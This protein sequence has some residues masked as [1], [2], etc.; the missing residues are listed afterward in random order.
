[1]VLSMEKGIADLLQKVLQE[2]DLGTLKGPPCRVAGGLMHT[3][4]A[5]VTERGKYAV[6]VLNPAV[7][8]REKALENTIFSEKIARELSKKIPVVPA[9]CKNGEAVSARNGCYYMVFPWQSGKNVF[10]KEIT[11]LHCER[12]GG[13]LGA[14]HHA[15]VQI[16]GAA[17][18]EAG[19][20]AP[21]WKTVLQK[22]RQEKPSWLRLFTA[23][24]ERIAGWTQRYVAAAEKRSGEQV[25]SHRDLDPKNVLWDG[26]EPFLIDW[27]AAG[28]VNPERELIEVVNY[29]ACNQRGR[30]DREKFRA[31]LAAYQMNRPLLHTDWPA[32]LDS[33]YGG[34][35][36]WLLYNMKRSLGIE[37]SSQ[38][39]RRLGTAQVR[40]TLHALD[41]YERKTALL[42]EWL[43][44]DCD[45]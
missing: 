36:E 21:D 12:I 15:N 10:A 25:L 3:M 6:K 19:A 31:L 2:M 30:L 44:E 39:E 24:Y 37:C 45:A 41:A 1:M 16:D 35:L 20:F 18:G 38:E 28:Y 8:K 23:R 11:P 42:L 32:V 43:R 17:Y 5:A 34:M 27:E 33:G 14:I 13:I 22:A 26:M 9:I 29:W 4:Y 7:M 40:G